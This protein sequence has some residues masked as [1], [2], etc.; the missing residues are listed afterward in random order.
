M[1]KMAMKVGAIEEFLLDLTGCL[2]AD[3][4]DSMTSKTVDVMYREKR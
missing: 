3:E 2:F 4:N 1:L